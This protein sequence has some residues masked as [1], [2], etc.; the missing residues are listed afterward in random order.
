MNVKIVEQYIPLAIKYAQPIQRANK[1]V[2]LVF[3]KK[4][5]L[6]YGTNAYKSDPKSIQHGYLFGDRHSELAA[7]V[8]V[9]HKI[10]NKSLCLV[11]YHFNTAL[12]IKM[13][14]PCNKCLPW[15]TEI[16]DDIWYTTPDGICQLRKWS[17]D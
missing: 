2:S 7:Y 14:K 12:Q 8:K 1:H 5:V 9:R 6:A 17:I 16:F 11:N 3:C 4:Q 10:N 13:A 15:V